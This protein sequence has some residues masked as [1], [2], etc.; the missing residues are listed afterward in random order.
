MGKK[1]NKHVGKQKN[2]PKGGER[3]VIGARNVCRKSPLD[4]EAIAFMALSV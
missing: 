3:E 2:K 4:L 1:H